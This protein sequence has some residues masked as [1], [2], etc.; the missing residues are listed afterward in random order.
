MFLFSLHS[1]GGSACGA[2]G[3]GSALIYAPATCASTDELRALALA[4][5]EYGGAYI[6]HVRSESAQLLEAIDETIEIDR[7]SV[8]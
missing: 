6:S 1:S 8:V 7:K 3:V 4:A 5:A 2:L